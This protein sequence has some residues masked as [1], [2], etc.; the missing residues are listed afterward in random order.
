MVE[1]IKV[2]P[3][4]IERID[5]PQTVLALEQQVAL[6]GLP[7]RH[8]AAPEQLAIVRRAI[9]EISPRGR[10]RGSQNCSSG[11]AQQPRHADKRLP[12]AVI[13]RQVALPAGVATEQLVRALAHL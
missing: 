12:G 4:D 6:L 13:K 5:V 10:E 9:Q 8:R 3:N 2:R 11:L 1:P 7:E